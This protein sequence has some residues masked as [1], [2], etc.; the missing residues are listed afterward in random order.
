VR[1]DCTMEGLDGGGKKGVPRLLGGTPFFPLHY[2]FQTNDVGTDDGTA[3]SLVES[4]L[5]LLL[6]K[7]YYLDEQNVIDVER[8]EP[9]ILHLPVILCAVISHVVLTYGY[10]SVSE[11]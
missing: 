7:R 10:P 3:W 8:A 1:I 9:R 6:L 11:P 4:L 2:S 5:S